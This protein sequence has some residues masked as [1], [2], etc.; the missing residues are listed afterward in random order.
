MAKESNHSGEKKFLFWATVVVA[1][2]L[3]IALLA[4]FFP[5]LAWA[6]VFSIL[7]KPLF[8]NM[9]QR[10]GVNWA[11]IISILA[12]LTLIIVPMIVIGALTYSQVTEVVGEFR[13]SAP[14]VKSDPEGLDGIIAQLDR[15]IQ[16]MAERMGAKVSLTQW[17]A[18]NKETL[19]DSIKP[20]LPVALKHMASSLLNFVIALLTMFFMLRDGHRL[21][22]PA[23]ELLPFEPD[24]SERLLTNI[25]NTVQA[26]FYS[27]VAVGLLQGALATI[28]YFATGVPHALVFGVMTTI[29]CVIPLLGGPILYVPL[30]LV[31]LSQGKTVNAIVLW[32]VGFG[33]I[34]NVDNILRPIIVSQRVPLHPI[35]IFF[36][37]LGGIILCGP[38]GL[39]VGPG[40]L[41]VLVCLQDFVR[42]INRAKTLPA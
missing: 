21:R 10:F 37:L 30:G 42:E 15:S 35:A 23:I 16:P 13:S 33:I 7:A 1:A 3:G 41:A 12:T 36:S 2:A 25:V 32:A 17:Y 26:V 8:N 24:Q 11:G 9:A 22:K 5:A 31:L 4:P 6:T 39:F 28:L 14:Y 29:L 19:F 20:M 38:V 18:D 40:I 34:S 27:I